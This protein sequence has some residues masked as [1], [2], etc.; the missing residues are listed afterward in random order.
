MRGLWKAA[1]VFWNSG[2]VPCHVF[3]GNIL[4]MFFLHQSEKKNGLN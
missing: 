1:E 3:L 4:L 2:T